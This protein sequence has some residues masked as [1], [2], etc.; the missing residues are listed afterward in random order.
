ALG[1]DFRYVILVKPQ[2]E[3]GKGNVHQG[4]VRSDE[5]RAA[6]VGAACDAI[7]ALGLPIS[8]IMASPLD[9]EHGNR[10]AIVYGDPTMSLDAREW[11]NHAAT[12]WGG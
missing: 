5:L 10:E 2:F 11:E 4:V 1:R 9:G 8:G 7:V 3:V 12:I 6:A